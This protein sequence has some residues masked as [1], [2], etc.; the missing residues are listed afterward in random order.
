[1]EA[2]TTAA[3]RTPLRAQG[4]R[5]A[6]SWIDR[7]GLIVVLLALPVLCAVGDLAGWDKFLFVE[8]SNDG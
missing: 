3:R 5:A 6:A 8:F 1:M 7:Y 2:A 4:D